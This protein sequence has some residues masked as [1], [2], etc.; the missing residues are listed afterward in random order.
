[1]ATKIKALAKFLGCKKKEIEESNYNDS[2]FE[3]YD[4]EYLVVTDE[5]G[6][7][8]WDDYLESY[9]D[10]CILHEFPEGYRNYFDRESWKSDARYA[11]RA[12]SLATYDGDENEQDGYY[13]Y[14]TN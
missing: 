6:D 7:E 9:I 8:M 11:G 14:R 3:Y 5:E 2:V 10:E 4:Q 1:M 13:I 12:H